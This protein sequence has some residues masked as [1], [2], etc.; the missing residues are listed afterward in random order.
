[1]KMHKEWYADKDREVYY[2]ADCKFEVTKL[3][4]FNNWGEEELY[5]DCLNRVAVD[6]LG[7][8]CE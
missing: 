2:C 8:S 7:Q 3:Q 1:M 5:Q 6:I 4:L